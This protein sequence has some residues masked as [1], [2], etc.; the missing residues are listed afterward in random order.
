MEDIHI[1]ERLLWTN[2]CQLL[3][4][5][6]YDEAH[7]ILT[8]NPSLIGKIFNADVNGALN[9]MRKSRVVDMNIRIVFAT[10][11]KRLISSLTD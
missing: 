4:Q 8:S 1:A 9:I 5:N 6:K 2:F 7:Q 3:N 11:H 10:L